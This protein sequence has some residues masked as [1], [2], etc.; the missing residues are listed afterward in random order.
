MPLNEPLPFTLSHERLEVYRVT[1][2]LHT[3]ALL[4]PSRARPRSPS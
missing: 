3:L 2:E 4:A 1:V